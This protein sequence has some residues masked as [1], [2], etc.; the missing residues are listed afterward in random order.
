MKTATKH[1]YIC[2]I[3]NQMLGEYNEEELRQYFF[4]NEYNRF[5]V[6]DDDTLAQG[7]KLALIKEQR[8]IDGKKTN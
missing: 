5:K 1:D 6:L 7:Y 3:V 8:K 2:A 4:D